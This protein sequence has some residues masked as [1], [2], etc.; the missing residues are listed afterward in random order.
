MPTV[1]AAMR[2]GS[3]PSA[4]PEPAIAV[5]T[6]VSQSTVHTKST[7]GTPPSGNRTPLV[8]TAAA[9]PTMTVATIQRGTVYRSRT[10]PRTASTSAP[11]TTA[12]ARSGTAVAMTR[13][14]GTATTSTMPPE[15]RAHFQRDRRAVARSIAP[16]ASTTTP[17]TANA[18][19]TRTPMDQA[20]LRRAEPGRRSIEGAYRPPARR[21]RRAGARAQV[22]SDRSVG[23]PTNEVSKRPRGAPSSCA[24]RD[25]QP[26]P[27][28][29]RDVAR[30]DGA[31]ARRAWRGPPGRRAEIAPGDPGR[32][33]E[34]RCVGDRAPRRSPA[35][36]AP[37]PGARAP[38]TSR[39]RAPPVVRSR[40][41]RAHRGPPRRHPGRLHVGQRRVRPRAP[42][43]VLGPPSQAARGPDRR[44]D[45]GPAGDAAPRDLVPRR[46]HHG[47]AAPLPPRPDPRDPPR[48]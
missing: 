20:F 6:S 38:T 43:R 19:A 15:R 1:D 36:V 29:R 42:G 24:V 11:A 37:N 5:V 30:R 40:P 48:P 14:I 34:H 10:N 25:R 2:L 31:R 35:L 9:T 12:S 23:C 46:R 3:W 26:H 17:E 8:V 18:I 27:G 22:G 16:T 32:G 7:V 39:P 45:H 47:P 41:R 44:R 13:P 4:L 33:R 21:H 28:G